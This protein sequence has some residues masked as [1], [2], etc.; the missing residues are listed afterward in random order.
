VSL[1]AYERP[2]LHAPG[3]DGARELTVAELLAWTGAERLD[4][5]S[6]R[7]V[8]R[9][10]RR[11]GLTAT[12]DLFDLLADRGE[13]DW[14]PAFDAGGL[15]AT[16]P[17]LDVRVSVRTTTVPI[18]VG[19]AFMTLVAASIGWYRWPPYGVFALLVGAATGA[20]LWRWFDVV[21]RRLPAIVPRT[22]VLGGGLVA[23]VL[24]A[25]L[26]GLVAIRRITGL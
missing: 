20:A 8:T 6:A 13:E 11:R 23:L 14:T 18:L 26:V 24:F 7:D 9:A 1:T 22:G 25:G 3:P 4:E 2:E 5:A 12:P 16:G 19:V 10:L 15:V 17:A 21:D